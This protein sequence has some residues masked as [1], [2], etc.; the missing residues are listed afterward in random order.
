MAALFNVVPKTTVNAKN[1]TTRVLLKGLRTRDLTGYDE[2]RQAAVFD[3]M[4]AANIP[5]IDSSIFSISITYPGMSSPICTGF[6]NRE[7]NNGRCILSK[8]AILQQSN[9]GQ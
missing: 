7:L 1:G 9:Q 4:L 2:E 3:E 6:R 8:I 5:D